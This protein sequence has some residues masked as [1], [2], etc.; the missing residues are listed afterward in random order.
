M[1]PGGRPPVGPAIHMRLPADLLLCVDQLADA[2][3]V[4]R[5]EMVRRLVRA[6]LDAHLARTGRKSCP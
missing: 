2:E 5:A 6:G 4:S 1:S 3:Q